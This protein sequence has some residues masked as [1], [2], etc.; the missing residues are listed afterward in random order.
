[1][2]RFFAAAALLLIASS[3]SIAYAQQPAGAVA[4]DAKTT[5]AYGVLVLRRAAAEAE[6]QKMLT[7]LREQHPD[8]GLK[9]FEVDALTREMERMRVTEESGVPKLTSTY[10]T[11]ILRQVEVEVELETLL[12]RLSE[13]HPDV[14]NKRTELGILRR[15]IEKV[16][17]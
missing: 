7:M 5:P 6:L 14:R 13:R 9:K 12:T 8:V 11:L 16:L 2:K 1:M 17:R 3:V 15:E 4:I 10:G